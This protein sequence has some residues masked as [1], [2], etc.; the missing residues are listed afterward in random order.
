MHSVYSTNMHDEHMQ[1]IKILLCAR[2]WPYSIELMAFDR[3]KRGN[4]DIMKLRGR[5]IRC[6]LLS[7]PSLLPFLSP[8]SSYSPCFLSIFISLSQ[9]LP[10]PPFLYS[11]QPCLCFFLILTCILTFTYTFCLFFSTF[12]MTYIVWEVNLSGLS[13]DRFSCNHS[14]LTKKK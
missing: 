3:V 13:V 11:Q 4:H 7:F 2:I 12:M 6:D 14:S 1:L 5:A 8:A 10:F 9:P